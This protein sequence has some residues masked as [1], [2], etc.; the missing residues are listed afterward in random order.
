MKRAVA[1]LACATMA[2]LTAGAAMSD[3]SSRHQSDL[4][5]I[6]PMGRMILVNGHQVHLYC[7]GAGAPTVIL[8]AG[9]GWASLNWAWVQRD[10]A[11]TTRV[12]SYDRPE[13]GW[14]D[15]SDVPMDAANTSAQ[16]YALLQAASE[17][18]PYIIVG[19]SLG[20][21]Y[22][23]MFAAKHRSEV[24]GLVLVDA[25]NPSHETTAAEV[26]LP[27]LAPA[28]SAAFVASNDI[29]WQLAVGLG[30]VRSTIAVDVTDF[31]PDLA[32]AMK[33][34]L[35]S[36]Q[37]ARAA[38][39]EGGSLSDTLSQI[40]SLGSLGNLPVTVIASDRWVDADAETAAKRA[41]WNKRQQRNWLAISTNSRFLII[42]GADHLSLLSNKD[43][44]HAV[45]DV[46]VKMAAGRR[47]H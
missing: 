12:C 6:P 26:G 36:L 15:R 38:A 11:K 28:A 24:A 18:G 16:L 37:R 47:R 30:I 17:K 32:P 21:A 4:A 10:I 45:A 19:Q 27:R 42:P 8:E 35:P 14:S 43:H 44:A 13:Y 23:R 2:M 39:R 9:L 1:Q 20:G 22:A 46:V 41:E 5:S 25:T 33:V 3:C 29:L 31:P 7:T 40:R 34:F